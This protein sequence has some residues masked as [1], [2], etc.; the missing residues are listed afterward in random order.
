MSR[1]PKNY[2][3]D[4]A[5]AARAPGLLIGRRRLVGRYWW[6]WLPRRILNAVWHAARG[7]RAEYPLCCIL[8]FAWDDLVCCM[9]GE[10]RGVEGTEWIPCG[11]CL[12]R[13]VRA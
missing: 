8:R 2:V 1:S 10:E 6:P 9:S 7:W 11:R 5:L 13:L 4:A 12:R 3:V